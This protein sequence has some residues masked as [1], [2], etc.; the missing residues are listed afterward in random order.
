MYCMFMLACVYYRLDFDVG[1]LLDKAI[2]VCFIKSK[3]NNFINKFYVFTT[4]LYKL[5]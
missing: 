5:V 4:I 2:G 3:K 1:L